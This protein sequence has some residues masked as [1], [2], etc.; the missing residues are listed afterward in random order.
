MSISN[1]TDHDMVILA[2]AKE[3]ASWLWSVRYA[4]S[5]L[6]IVLLPG[7][8]YQLHKRPVSVSSDWRLYLKLVITTLFFIQQLVTGYV[9]ISESAVASPVPV[10]LLPAA[11]LGLVI[12]SHS[13]HR[14]S[15]K[16]SSLILLYL[17]ISCLCDLV[18][19]TIPSLRHLDNHNDRLIIG[20]QLVAKIVVFYVECL[21]KESVVDEEEEIGHGSLEERASFLS[22]AF[23]SWISPV[24]KEGYR[25][26][27]VNEKLPS[28]DHELASG[29]LRASILRTLF[30]Y[31]SSPFALVLFRCLRAPFLTVIVP[32]LF[33]IGFRYGQPVLIRYAI[34]YVQ[35]PETNEDQGYTLVSVAAIV[36]I[37]L[38]LSTRAYQQG[39]NRLQVMIRGALLG[40]VHEHSLLARHELYSKAKTV[41]IASTDVSAL[42]GAPR[43]LHESWALLVEVVIGSVLLAKQVGWLWPVPHVIIIVC[44]RVSK[45]VARNL[46]SSQATWNT[47][48]QGRISAT[49]TMLGSIKTIKML[50][51]QSIVEKHILGLRQEELDKAKRVRWIMAIYNASAN[52]LGMFAPVIT[53]VLFAIIA[54]VNGTTLDTKTAF[55]TIA[56]LALVTHSANMVMTIVPQ[57]IAAYASFDRIEDYIKS[58]KAVSRSPRPGQLA[59]GIEVSIRGLTVKWTPEQSNPTLEDVNLELSRGKVVA[60]LG[61]VGSGK[62]SLA[63]AILGEVPLVKGAVTYATDRIAY[64]SQV[65]WLPNR[66]IKQVIRGSMTIYGDIDHDWYLAV[67]RA[68]CLDQDLAVLPDGDETMVGVDGMNLSGGQRQRVALA[69]AVY[70]RCKVVVLDDPFSALDG[71]TRDQVAQNLLGPKG[72]FRQLNAAVFWITSSTKNVNLSDNVIILERRITEQ[73]TWEELRDKH[74]QITDYFR[75]DASNTSDEEQSKP[76]VV[77]KTKARSS[78]TSSTDD[79]RRSQGDLS[80]Y[81][82]TASYSFFITFPQYWV[83][84]WTQ[85]DELDSASKRNT[86]YYAL[87]YALLYLMA[88][89]S[90][91]GTMLSAVFRIAPT[92]GLNL[93]RSLVHTIMHAPLFFFSMADMGVLLNYFS[94]DVQLVDKT[95][96]Q[97]VMSFAIQVCKMIVQASLLLAAQPIMVVTLPVCAA[98]VYTIQKVYLRT[99]RQLRLLEL[100]SRAAVNSSLLETVQGIETIR[101]FGWRTEAAIENIHVV[102][103]SQRPFY[104]LL[105][106]QRWLNVVLDLLV[107]GV[108]VGTIFLAV[109]LKGTVTGGQIGVALSVIIA[110]NATLLSLVQSWTNLEISLGAISRLKRVEEDTPQEPVSVPCPGHTSPNHR[111]FTGWPSPDLHDNTPGLVRFEG[112]SA[113]YT[114][115]GPLVLQDLNLDIA[116]GQVVVICGRTGSGKSSLLL[117]MLRLINIRDGTLRIGN[118]DIRQAP[119]HTIR[120]KAFITVTQDPFHLSDASLRFNLD[121][122]CLLPNDALISVL[123]LL[124]LW[125]HLSS[126]SSNNYPYSEHPVIDETSPLLNTTTTPS[127][128]PSYHPIL[129]TPLSLLP[130]LS[131]GHLQLLSLCRAIIKARHMRSTINVAQAQAAVPEEEEE[132]R[133]GDT[134]TSTDPEDFSSSASSSFSSSSSDPGFRKPDDIIM[135]PIILLDEITASLDEKTEQMVLR[136]VKEEFLANKYTVLMVT[137]RVEAVRGALLGVEDLVVVSMEGGKIVGVE[138]VGA[139]GRR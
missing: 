137:H 5:A 114:S 95:L 6:F 100:E 45:Y 43:M 120:E 76:S 107:A 4:T 99:S 38:A 74:Q 52:A 69:R 86:V 63:R 139:H 112:V 87:G 123:Q 66:T 125:F 67:V 118:K 30:E 3:L 15:V 105:C 127:P 111:P 94:Q 39:L 1:F 83:K 68:C 117:A 34:E 24:L 47:A 71:K 61:P 64:C 89:I 113:S 40:V 82:C 18:Q 122:T 62:T 136:V 36:Y 106:L 81:S 138:K 102:D 53:I 78:P 88:W 48:T 10:A 37:G 124:G 90:T 13:E 31:S 101:A 73:G 130:T 72:L 96:A 9:F 17:L 57:A 115:N 93:H 79:L 25:M 129:D 20:W 97:A 55:P 29:N 85:N 84:W 103:I 77:T 133:R 110:A 80:L 59:E 131:T 50:G 75:E 12:L 28:V 14:R 134:T 16:P 56:I 128:S 119:L 8:L 44:S 116:S 126:S 41:A 49:S 92:S 132:Y 32:R 26:V 121:P 35:S 135:Q 51:L 11:S 98:V 109:S 104:L 70:H 22:R 58:I 19:L 65:P 2:D 23:V 21:A 60:C 91:N 7:R 27:L 108:A 46:R 54:M 42:E 33:V